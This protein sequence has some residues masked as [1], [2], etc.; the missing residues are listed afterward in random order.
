[1]VDD[2]T[3]LHRWKYYDLAVLSWLSC[4]SHPGCIAPRAPE[5][6]NSCEDFLGAKLFYLS[7]CLSSP[8]YFLLCVAI[9]YTIHILFFARFHPPSLSFIYSIMSQPLTLIFSSITLIIFPFP[10][11]ARSLPLLAPCVFFI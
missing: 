6:K 11:L 2:S 7:V 3:P 8:S 9:F 5:P 10:F 1:M 4:L